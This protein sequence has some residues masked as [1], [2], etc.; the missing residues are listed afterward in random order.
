[1]WMD[2]FHRMGI[3][4]VDGKSLSTYFISIFYEKG[5]NANCV[6]NAGLCLHCDTNIVLCKKAVQK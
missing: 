2:L 5:E 6:R 1:M 4:A 3:K